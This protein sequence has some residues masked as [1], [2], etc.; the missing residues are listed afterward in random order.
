MSRAVL[1]EWVKS[2]LMILAMVLFTKSFAFASNYIPSESMVP[3]L[4]VGD[5][6]FVSRFPYG[7]SRHSL[8]IDPGLSLPGENGRLPSLLP[9]RGDVVTFIHPQH[10]EV[11]IKRVIGLPGD[12]IALQG[13][14][15]II[16]GKIVPRTPTDRYVYRDTY[17]SPVAVT[18]YREDLPGGRAHAIIERRD[19]GAADNLP[20]VTVPAGHLFMM[21]DNRDNS[22][23]SRFSAMG[24][25]PVENLTGRAEAVMWSLYSCDP[26]AGLHCAGRR[27]LT[28]IE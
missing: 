21:G 11:M 26:A 3:T 16:N 2:G 6:L 17:G 13:G 12:R 20:E 1:I 18:R 24:F 7:V 15:L 8:A 4:E 22:A 25:V 14:R 10:G 5:R 23:D 9:A 19:D 27:A 28:W